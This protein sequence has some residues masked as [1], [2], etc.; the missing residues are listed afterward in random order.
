MKDTELF[1]LN[2]SDLDTSL[3]GVIF[4]VHFRHGKVISVTVVEGRSHFLT[5]DTSHWL[6]TAIEQAQQ[7]IDA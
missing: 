4:E 2:G 3:V 7:I 5:V 1:L 6:D